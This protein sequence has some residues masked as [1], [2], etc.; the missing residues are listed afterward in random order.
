MNVL[1]FD[2]LHLKY[3]QMFPLPIDFFDYTPLIIRF[4][5]L[6]KYNIPNVKIR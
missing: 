1:R 5:Y 3:P 2:K 6:P 4:K